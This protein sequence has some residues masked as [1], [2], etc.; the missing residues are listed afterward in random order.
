MKF[1]DWI[2]IK[3]NGKSKTQIC[4]DFGITRPT[5]D[6]WMSDPEMVYDQKLKQIKTVRV[7]KQL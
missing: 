4:K 1:K 6:A 5:L 3:H 2:Q 7:V